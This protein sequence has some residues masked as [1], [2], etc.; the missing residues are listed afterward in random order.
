MRKL[1]NQCRD[2]LT[3]NVRLFFI[4]CLHLGGGQQFSVILSHP[5]PPPAPLNCISQEES[6]LQT[7]GKEG[8]DARRH[9]QQADLAA[10]EAEVKDLKAADSQVVGMEYS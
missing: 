4:A 10:V 5:P 3:K 8:F 9:K 7:A 2:N 6:S 1:L